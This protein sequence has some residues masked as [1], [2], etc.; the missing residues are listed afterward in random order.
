M[1]LEEAVAQ[2]LEEYYEEWSDPK[3]VEEG[4]WKGDKEF[5]LGFNPKFCQENWKWMME[6]VVPLFKSMVGKAIADSHERFRPEDRQAQVDKEEET[7]MRFFHSQW[8]M[9]DGIHDWL[10][11]QPIDFNKLVKARNPNIIETGLP[12]GRGARLEQR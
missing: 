10:L 1:T 12:P 5:V 6:Q 11:E 2:R 8:A 4:V 9:I 3:Y 7:F